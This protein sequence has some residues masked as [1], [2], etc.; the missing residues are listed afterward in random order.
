MH[1]TEVHHA[2]HFMH[3]E[4]RLLQI[5]LDDPEQPVQQFNIVGRAAASRWRQQFISPALFIR[6][7]D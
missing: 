7:L 4:I 5:I 2:A 6:Q 1:V 3:V